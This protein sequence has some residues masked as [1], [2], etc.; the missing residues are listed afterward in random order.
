MDTFKVKAWLHISAALS[1]ERHWD[2][3]ES[4]YWE[5]LGY[6]NMRAVH[7]WLTKTK[8]SVTY[9]LWINKWPL[10]SCKRLSSKWKI[11]AEFLISQEK[12]AS[13]VNDTLKG[14]YHFLH[15]FQHCW[16]L[17][18]ILSL[19][20]GKYNGFL[21]APSY[22]EQ[23]EGSSVSRQ[24]RKRIRCYKSKLHSC[25]L[26]EFSWEFGIPIFKM[27]TLIS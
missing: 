10:F 24:S 19:E 2:I 5:S 15:V 11:F 21:I 27:Y 26:F 4:D 17:I 22:K 14:S 12:F 20:R 6:K 25:A 13:Q 8:T 23:M 7:V 16:I 1:A 18:Y 9:E 3:L